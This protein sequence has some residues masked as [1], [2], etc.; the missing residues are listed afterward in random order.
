MHVRAYVLISL[1]FI[2]RAKIFDFEDNFFR[3]VIFL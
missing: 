1:L 3:V 2:L